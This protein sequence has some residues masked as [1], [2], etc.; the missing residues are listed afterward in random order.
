MEFKPGD[1]L[2]FM[3]LCLLSVLLVCFLLTGC[4]QGT[5]KNNNAIKFAVCLDYPP[6]EYNYKGELRG[7]DIELAKLIGKEIKKEVEFIDM[8]FSNILPAI[9]SGIADAGISTLHSSKVR[10]KNFSFSSPYHFEDIAIIY[11]KDKPIL[12]I[13]M[14]KRQKIAV[15]L[16]TI[17]EEWA[18]NI[19]NINLI[20]KTTTMHSIES[21]KAKHVDGV[22]LD[23]SQAKLFTKKEHRFSFFY[24]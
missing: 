3:R 16:G 20:L 8:D 7:F 2:D 14:V 11:R 9:Q 19:P 10:E 22:I 13:P 4:D 17:H 18:R 1:Y 6:F 15:Q 5:K 12:N 24:A 21:L 23:E